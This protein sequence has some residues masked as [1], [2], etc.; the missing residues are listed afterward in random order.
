VVARG[1]EPGV[2][3]PLADALVLAAC[4]DLPVP[5]QV[6]VAGVGLDGE[7]PADKVRA[8]LQAV[9]G[10]IDTILAPG[11]LAGVPG[12]DAVFGWHPSEAT[13]MLVA[14]VSGARGIVEV[15]D[16]GMQIVLDDACL[17]VWHC[18]APELAAGSLLA[19]RLAGTATLAQSEDI[20]RD[21]CGFCEIDYERAKAARRAGA[22]PEPVNLAAVQ[23]RV[24]AFSTGCAGRGADYVTFRRLAE[25]TGFTGSDYE[26]VRAHLVQQQPQAGA[27]PLW[28]VRDRPTG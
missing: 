22:S 11:D 26:R 1:D 13:A 16:G 2:K 8:R 19:P 23:A 25:A 14:S 20:V 7:L 17:Q 28:P 3:S 21:V 12:L 24:N 6:M 4:A 15:R 9:G 27:V 10:D 5:A 18:P